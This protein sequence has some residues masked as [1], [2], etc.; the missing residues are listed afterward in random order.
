MLHTYFSAVDT[1]AVV[2]NS[3]DLC[4]PMGADVIRLTPHQLRGTRT[5]QYALTRTSLH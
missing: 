2:S 4:V 5:D 1:T 3:V